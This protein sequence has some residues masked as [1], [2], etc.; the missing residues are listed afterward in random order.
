MTKMEMSS[1]RGR[2]SL[3]QLSSKQKRYLVHARETYLIAGR[4]KLEE[5]GQESQRPKYFGELPRRTSSN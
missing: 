1:Y 5:V 3:W 4:E 2:R